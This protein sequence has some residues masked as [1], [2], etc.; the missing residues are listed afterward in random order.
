MRRSI[1]THLINTKSRIE[2]SPARVKELA[3]QGLTDQQIAKALKMSHTTFRMRLNKELSFLTAWTEGKKI[4]GT[5]TRSI[6]SQEA[7]EEEMPEQPQ[8][9]II[10]KA[11]TKRRFNKQPL[12]TEK[13]AALLRNITGFD[14][15]V[16]VTSLERLV[17]RQRATVEEGIVFTTYRANA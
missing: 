13:R 2:A 7:W 8:D 11:L 14:L 17:A 15:S 9:A 3:A 5:F 12:P 10:L 16:V 1:N 6:A 4:A